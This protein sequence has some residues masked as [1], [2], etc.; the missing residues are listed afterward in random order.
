MEFKFQWNSILAT[1]KVLS[2][3]FHC[4]LIPFLASC[5][6]CCRTVVHHHHGEFR[7]VELMRCKVNLFNKTVIIELG[8]FWIFRDQGEHQVIQ[9]FKSAALSSSAIYI[10][11]W[12][13][14]D[15]LQSLMNKIIFLGL[16]LLHTTYIEGMI[17]TQTTL[18]AFRISYIDSIKQEFG[19]RQLQDSQRL[20]SFYGTRHGIATAG[21]G[22][23]STS[24]VQ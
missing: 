16:S 5:I 20:K 6:I 4:R 11:I 1:S 12:R 10:Y 15:R 14:E 2:Q 17:S 22:G 23:G 7:S 13:A 18:V 3:Y 21:Q 24:P 19:L 8:A 9:N